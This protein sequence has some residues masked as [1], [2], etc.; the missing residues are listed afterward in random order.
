MSVHKCNVENEPVP[1]TSKE[2]AKKSRQRA[3]WSEEKKEERREKE[4]LRQAKKRAA[5][6]EKEKEEQREKEKQRWKER[7]GNRSEEQKQ[8]L[9]RSDRL[10][11]Q[12]D[13]ENMLE[14]EVA[15]LNE[16]SR[17]ANETHRRVKKSK[18]T[19][20]D[21]LRNLEVL[22]GSFVVQRLEDSLDAIGRMDVK[23]QHCG[24]FKFKRESEGFC[25]SSGKVKTAP[26]PKPPG[27]LSEL[28]KSNGAE[29]KLL[30]KFSRE[31]NNAVAL[32]KL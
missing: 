22:D 17:V 3:N 29:G 4:R 32:S 6:T 26:F 15:A 14:D 28:W 11:H 13:R 30:K 10:R 2:T 1:S 25:C 9:R 5:R 20:N 27:K 18:A 31:L 19:K 23:C 16:R 12:R 7:Q 21:G 8:E 24:A